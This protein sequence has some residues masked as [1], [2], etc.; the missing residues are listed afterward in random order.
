MAAD[1]LEARLQELQR[2]VN[3]ERGRIVQLE[4]DTNDGVS[5]LD[6]ARRDKQQATN[7]GG[8]WERSLPYYGGYACSSRSG[9]VNKCPSLSLVMFT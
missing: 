5:S 1:S 6:Y 4:R 3:A 7:K 9:A 8:T 2:I